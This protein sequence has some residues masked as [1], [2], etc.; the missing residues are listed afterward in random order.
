MNTRKLK[1]K[2]TRKLGGLAREVERDNKSKVRHAALCESAMLAEA[3]KAGKKP[4]RVTHGGKPYKK[5]ARP[6]IIRDREPWEQIEDGVLRL[7]RIGL[8]E[9][10][11]LNLPSLGFVYTSQG[12]STLQ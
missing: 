5:P 10:L 9:G 1:Q 2:R 7:K 12:W 3:I 11:S 6:S 8:Q 4:A